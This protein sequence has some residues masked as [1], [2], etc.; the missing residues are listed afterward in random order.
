MAGLAAMA[1]AADDGDDAGGTEAAD[2]A[3]EADD[4]AVAAPLEDMDDRIVS[5]GGPSPDPANV[6]NGVDVASANGD[7][8]TQAAAG[9]TA[10]PTASVAPE[11]RAVV[12]D[13][14]RAV[15]S[16]PAKTRGMLRYYRKEGPAKPLDAH[17]AGGGDGDRTNA[18]A[19]NRTLRTNGLIEHVGRGN[20]AYRLRDLVAEEYGGEPSEAELDAMVDIVEAAF[21]KGDG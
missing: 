1:G 11:D 4:E 20:Y 16:M 14:V 12:K 17:F 8:G 19:H 21:V 10:E 3:D 13:L 18:Y 15:G 6:S 9:S 2:G 5:G 7:G